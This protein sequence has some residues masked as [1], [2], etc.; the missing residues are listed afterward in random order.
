MLDPLFLP[1]FL[2]NL[3]KPEIDSVSKLS[4]FLTPC[5]LLYLCSS[6]QFVSPFR[7]CWLNYS[8]KHI[9][10]SCTHLGFI[11]SIQYKYWLQM[12]LK[13]QQHTEVNMKLIPDQRVKRNILKMT[14]RLWCDIL[15]FN[16]SLK[17]TKDINESVTWNL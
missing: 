12:D 1:F 6:L 8:R 11:Y 10:S 5:F 4:F 16:K 3:F 9:H 14:C 2:F 7:P 13:K 15:Q 17:S